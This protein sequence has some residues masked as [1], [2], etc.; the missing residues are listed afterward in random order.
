ME[1]EK[2]EK[3]YDFFYL[4]VH[5]VPFKYSTLIELWLPMYRTF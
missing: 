4:L 3:T 5:T 2:L 1:K